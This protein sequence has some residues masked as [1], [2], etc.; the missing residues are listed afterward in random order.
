VFLGSS[1]PSWVLAAGAG[2][3][4]AVPAVAVSSALT[5]GEP[6][7]RRASSRARWLTYALVG[8]AAAVFTG[9][10]I[11]LLLL[12]CGVVEA[13]VR[14][15]WAPRLHLAGIVPALAAVAARF[16]KSTEFAGWAALAWV[17]AKVGALSYGGGFVIIPLMRH[18]AVAR[19]A[20]MTD[21]QFLD[22]IALGQVTPGPVVQTVGVV[23]YAAG[24]VA[25][26]ALAAAVAFVPSF[27]I[28]LTLARHLP[29]LAD[30]APVRCFLDGAGAAAIGA[31]AGVAI[32]LSESVDTWWQ[33]AVL[34]MATTIL[35]TLR[36]GVVSV[37][38]VAAGIGVL[39]VGLGAPL[40]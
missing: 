34:G 21:R 39:S 12:A 22:A 14:Q 9:M 16:T 24:G 33:L 19:Y 15:A 2:A 26:A 17:A 32:P 1:P 31:I 13:A 25:G 37:L 38:V 11:V 30:N 10:W 7:W 6:S 3:G 36:R 8:A 23:G 4:A 40:A 28:I 5:L 35:C 18:D 27:V 20:W 29:R